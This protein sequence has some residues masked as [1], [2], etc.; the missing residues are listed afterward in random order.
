MKFAVV[1]SQPKSRKSVVMA[2]TVISTKWLLRS[3][4]EFISFGLENYILSDKIRAIISTLFEELSGIQENEST[5]PKR[6]INNNIFIHS[7][8][9]NFEQ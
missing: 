6:T 8:F 9:V 7:Q 3:S 5:K 1:R 4:R 2:L